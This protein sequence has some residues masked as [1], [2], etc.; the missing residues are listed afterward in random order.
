MK[1]DETVTVTVE[2]PKP[3]HDLVTKLAAVEGSTADEWYGEWIKREVEALLGDA[4]DVFDVERL[5]ESNGLR[6]VG[7]SAA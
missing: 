7:I 1:S 5:V 4:H 2:L 3:I 6:A